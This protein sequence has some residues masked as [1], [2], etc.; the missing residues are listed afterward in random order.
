MSAH[1]PRD[2]NQSH[3]RTFLLP[4]SAHSEKSLIKRVTDLALL[5][6]NNISL[7]DL[8]YTLGERRS[9][10]P[11]RGYLLAHLCTLHEDL[12]S[13]RLQTYKADAASSCLPFAFIF[14]GQGAQWPEMGRQL[15]ETFPKYRSTIQD[16]DAHL[17][18]LPH[19]PSW[20]L[21]GKHS[22]LDLER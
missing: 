9:I 10:F 1:I 4:F 15:M 18:R 21:R 22:I 13:I 8:A 3:R 6:L 14:T 19:P 20:T 17:A 11:V 7:V 12:S 16:L 2:H 5:D